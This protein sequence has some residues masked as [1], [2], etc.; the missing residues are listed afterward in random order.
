MNQLAPPC[1]I[2]VFSLCLIF[3]RPLRYIITDY[4]ALCQNSLYNHVRPKR[5]IEDTDFT[6][7]TLLGWVEQGQVST[8]IKWTIDNELLYHLSNNYNIISINL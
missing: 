2:C 1:N 5:P 3:Q 7:N 4:I 8:K 6:E